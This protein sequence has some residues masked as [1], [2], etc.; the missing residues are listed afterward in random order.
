MLSMVCFGNPGAWKY[1]GILNPHRIL[2]YT[3]AS[4]LAA[5]ND[6]QSASNSVKFIDL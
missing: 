6:G 2:A 3:S 1:L 5:H 4:S